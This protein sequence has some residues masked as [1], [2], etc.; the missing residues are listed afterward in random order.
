MRFCSVSASRSPRRSF[1]T[2]RDVALVEDVRGEA[3]PRHDHARGRL[4]QRD[5]EPARPCLSGLRAPGSCHP[6]QSRHRR[7]SPQAPWRA[8]WRRRVP[9][10]QRFLRVIEQSRRR[11]NGMGDGADRRAGEIQGHLFGTRVG[12][13]TR[14]GA[15]FH[16]YRPPRLPSS[17]ARTVAAL[18][19][20]IA[21]SKEHPECAPL[22]E[23]TRSMGGLGL[24]ADKLDPNEFAISPPSRSAGSQSC[25][26]TRRRFRRPSSA[27]VA[28]GCRRCQSI[29]VRSLR[30]MRVGAEVRPAR[31]AI[32]RTR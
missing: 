28:A 32:R 9:R 31:R 7:H 18:A 11:A 16:R 30:G 15:D 12:Q 24:Q 1:S 2:E 3:T 4:P 10:P 26:S 6:H 19:G 23:I 25:R 13:R 21:S 14:K 17:E 8:P 27:M 29:C 5:V 20:S 22:N